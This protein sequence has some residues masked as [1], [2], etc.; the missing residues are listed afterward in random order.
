MKITLK[1]ISLAVAG[2]TA[3]VGAYELRGGAMVR[4]T[5]VLMGLG[6]YQTIAHTVSRFVF[7]TI[8]QCV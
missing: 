3:G 8:L 1:L 5:C 2:A 6:S 4:V 7:A